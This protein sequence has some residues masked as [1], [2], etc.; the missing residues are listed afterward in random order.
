MTISHELQY[1]AEGNDGAKLVIHEDGSISATEEM[2]PWVDEALDIILEYKQKE[3]EDSSAI[4]ARLR[5][6]DLGEVTIEP[7]DEVPGREINL[8]KR[9]IWV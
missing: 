9:R 2:A 6:K 4:N 3:M 8:D 1:R 5:R 7:I